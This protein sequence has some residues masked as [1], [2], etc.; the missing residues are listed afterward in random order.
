MIVVGSLCVVR[1]LLCLVKDHYL[2]LDASLIH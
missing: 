1:G 2:L